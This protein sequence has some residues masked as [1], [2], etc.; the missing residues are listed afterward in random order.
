MERFI[1]EGK[2]P[3][4]ER[5]YR[6]SH[7]FTTE[8]DGDVEELEPWIQWITVHSGIPT[9]E[10]K[11]VN[12][13]DGHLLREKRVWDLVS[14][15]GRKIWVCGSMNV[16]YQAPVQGWI[17]PDPWT[18]EVKPHPASVLLPFFRFVSANV[19]DYT[20]D[21]AELSFADKLAF[22]LFM[23]R[24]GLSAETVKA[25][26]TQ[27]LSELR[28]SARTQWK[29]AAILDKLQFD[30]FRWV[31]RRERPAFSTFF[32]NSTAHF[33]HLYW[34]NLEPDVFSVKPTSAEQAAY[35]A[36]ILYGYQQMDD[37]VRRFLLLAGNE[38]TLVFC[39]AL[40]QQPCFV[41]DDK[42]G[43]R[44]YRP[45]DFERLLR[46]VGIGASARV[47]PVMA[48]QFQIDFDSEQAAI[49]AETK[50]HMLRYVDG[51]SAL[52]VNRSR[53]RILCGCRIIDEV[54]RDAVLRLGE[55]GRA[56]P[57]F[58]L[59]YRI[60]GIKSG[61]HHPD[62]MLWIRTP[63][64]RH[65]V[66]TAKVPLLSVAPTLLEMLGLPKPSY[67]AAEPILHRADASI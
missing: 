65:H 30:L 25:I 43:K 60:D 9:K 45:R 62:G 57:F 53:D 54:D 47:A 39:T 52:M 64:R 15:S 51:R 58:E 24:H 5:L 16:Q 66:E 7:V 40:S 8:S 35:E 55:S 27:L 59:F 56:I 21:R 38:A 63:S 28:R 14:D 22:V 13:G 19:L 29:R 33:Q 36:A 48:H 4:F 50:L 20:R 17:L 46:E 42:G 18:A 37:L 67:M 44:W 12:L 23:A 61:M 26:T 41:Y 6:E 32:S 3:S 1:K 49:E 31:Y 34:R 11:I 10:H 2:L